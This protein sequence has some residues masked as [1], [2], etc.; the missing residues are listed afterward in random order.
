MIPREW[1]LVTWSWSSFSWSR[2]IGVLGNIY[3]LSAYT[4]TS[5]T[6]HAWKPIHLVLTNKAVANILVLL[7]KGILQMIF[8]WGVTTSWA[9]LGVSLS[10]ISTEQP[11]AF[12]SAPLASWATFRQ[13][14]SVPELVG[15]WGS[16]TAW[17]NIRSSCSL[18]S[19][20]NLLIKHLCS[21]PF[22]G[23]S[24]SWQFYQAPGLWA[25]FFE[26]AWNI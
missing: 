6:G 4:S 9:A 19:I 10:T 23:S 12:P 13:S 1:F 16:K 20:S 26:K 24:A 25:V 2:G 11:E 3:L 22:R 14:P 21:Y 15:Q 18:C 7:F 5:C 17:K 8:I